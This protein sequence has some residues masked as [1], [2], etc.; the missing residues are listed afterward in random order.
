MSKTNL[1]NISSRFRYSITLKL[2]H[3]C[4]ANVCKWVHF[5]F[6]RLFL[7]NVYLYFCY[8]LYYIFD[9]AK[10][11]YCLLL[12]C[13]TLLVFHTFLSLVL[14]CSLLYLFL[15]TWILF[16]FFSTLCICSAFCQP[17]VPDCLCLLWQAF[18]HLLWFCADCL[19]FLTL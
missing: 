14:T 13:I 2:F 16:F 10:F 12:T 4:N 18:Q 7:S 19:A 17:P 1:N 8:Y 15:F 9:F 6:D 3:E 11:H 5:C